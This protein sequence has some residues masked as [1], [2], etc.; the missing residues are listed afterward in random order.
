MTVASA[1]RARVRERETRAGLVDVEGHR[2]RRT[3]QA[4]RA[5]LPG[6]SAC[7][8][9]GMRPGQLDSPVQSSGD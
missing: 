2:A 6:L 9:A 5:R 3:A 7:L 4:A 8:V 1:D